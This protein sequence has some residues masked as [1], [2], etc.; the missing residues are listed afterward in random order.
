MKL[1]KFGSTKEKQIAVV[2]L[3]TCF[4]S[5]ITYLLRIYC[6]HLL[7]C[8]VWK[9]LSPGLQRITEVWRRGLAWRGPRG[10][11]IGTPRYPYT[12]K[13]SHEDSMFLLDFLFPFSLEKY[14]RANMEGLSKSKD[15]RKLRFVD[16][17]P[18]IQVFR[19]CQARCA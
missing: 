13:G 3:H 15:L 9:D 1:G 10:A 12:G 4:L 16:K 14:Q 6:L 2:M 7:G 5:Q 17:H 8:V 18:P 19:H 11:H